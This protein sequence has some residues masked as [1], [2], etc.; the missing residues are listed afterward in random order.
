ME[1]TIAKPENTAAVRNIWEICFGDTRSYIDAFFTHVYKPEYTLVAIEDGEV[2]GS[3]QMLPRT[4][5]VNGTPV[6]SAYIGGVSVLPQ[7][8]NR[9][10]ASSLLQ[11]AEARLLKMGVKLTFLVPFLFSFYEKLGYKCISFLSEFSGETRALLPFS[12]INDLPLPTKMPQGNSYAAYSAGKPL[13]MQRED[14]LYT[15]EIFPL[16][17]HAEC[18]ALPEGAGHLL[19]EIKD[20]TLLVLDLCYKNIPSLRKLLGFIYEKRDMAPR[21]RIRTDA[22]GTLRMLLCENTITETRIPHG[23]IKSLDFQEVPVSMENYL[24]LTGWF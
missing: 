12:D 16:C 14:A 11:D 15:D 21:F 7:Y 5:F 23:M 19:Y 10:I 20:G 2:I 22:G 13:Y 24:H 1:I 3:L 6:K 8:R 18:A 4:L 17:E 9:R